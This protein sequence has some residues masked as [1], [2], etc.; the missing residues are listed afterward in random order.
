MRQVKWFVGGAFAAILCN[1]AYSQLLAMDII[2]DKVISKFESATC[3]T[4]W[5]ERAQG[6]N[7]QLTEREQRAL[8]TLREDPRIRADFFNR[9]SAPVLNK[10]FE[11]GMIP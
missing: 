3:Q 10:M 5:E 1:A 4:L 9:I 6:Q 7:R 8:Q 2:S 11:C